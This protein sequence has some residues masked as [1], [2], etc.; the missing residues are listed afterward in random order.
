MLKHVFFT[1]DQ[2]YVTFV[3]EFRKTC[4][5]QNIFCSLAFHCMSINLPNSDTPINLE[6]FF[7]LSADLFC[8]AGYDGYFK[9]V[10]SAVS[11]TLGYTNEE[12]FAKPIDEFVHP[13]DRDL[14]YNRREEIKQNN[15]LL[16][17]ENRYLT[18]SGEVVWLSWTSMPVDEEKLVFAIAKVITHKK[19]L[20]QDRNQLLSDLTKANHSL[21][22][23]TYTT[24]HDLRMPVSNLLSVFSL[25]DTSKITDAETLEFIDVLKLSAENLKETLNNYVDTLNEK[26]V[27]G[28]YV[29]ELNISDCLKAALYSLKSLI[30]DSKTHIDVD[31]SAFTNVRFNKAYLE[32][33]FLNLLTN[34][35]KYRKPGHAPVIT[36][37]TQVI[38]GIKQLIFSDQGVGFDMDKVKDK[39]FGLNQRFNDQADSKGIGLYLV[40]N[41]IISLG[42]RIAVDSEPD[43]GAVFTISF[44]E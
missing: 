18:K 17:F 31:L 36:I 15:P 44:V 3:V 16:N 5:V 37:K 20:D 29:E 22:Q 41:H 9:K 30:R 13:D 8:V 1:Y 33:I 39:I 34:S 43:K 21:Q 19:N 26:N 32:S 40:Y 2:C 28:V 42:G 7:A 14:T 24:S 38:N 35:I 23:L 4:H 11:K 12:L 6:Y 27:L 25:M 10:N